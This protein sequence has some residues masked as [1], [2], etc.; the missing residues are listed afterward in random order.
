MPRATA[1]PSASKAPPRSRSAI[2]PTFRA[3][4]HSRSLIIGSPLV[5]RVTKQYSIPFARAVRRPD[6]TLIGTVTSGHQR[7][8][9]HLRLYRERLRTAWRDGLRRHRRRHGPLTRLGNAGAI[10]RRP[11]AHAELGVVAGTGGSAEW[12]LLAG[13]HARRRAPCVCLPRD[14]RLS[15]RRHRGPCRCRYRRAIRGRGSRDVRQR[16]RRDADYSHRVD[17]LAT[18]ASRAQRTDPAT[19]GRDAGESSEERVL[20]QYEP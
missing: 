16:G 7:F 12:L 17:G 4:N 20:G 3:A 13:Q 6:G 2:G 5:A 10:A 19:R 14:T 11:V 15:G 9:L 8:G 1:R 18:A